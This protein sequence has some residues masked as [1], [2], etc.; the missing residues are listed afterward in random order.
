MIRGL[1]PSDI[2]YTLTEKLT[3][4]VDPESRVRGLPSFQAYHKRQGFL[5]DEK[6]YF[7][8]DRCHRDIPIAILLE[9]FTMDELLRL[10]ADDFIQ[11]TISE[12]IQKEHFLLWKIEN[13]LWQFEGGKR[14]PRPVAWGVN[15]LKR[16]SVDLPDFEIAVT[17]T[18]FYH[19]W[20]LTEHIEDLW[21]DAPMAALIYYRGEH[22]LTCSFAIRKRSIFVSQV[23]LRKKTGNRF[24]FK[25]KQH[26]LDFALD[27]LARAFGPN[28]WLTGGASA[29][30]AIRRAYGKAPCKMTTEDELRIAALYNRP[31]ERF[32]REGEPLVVQDREFIRLVPKAEAHPLQ[33]PKGRRPKRGRA[34]SAHPDHAQ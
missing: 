28:I 14:D 4:V 31:L 13:C 27:I 18:M 34:D 3:K 11:S 5:M 32:D 20:G 25:L 2:P 6:D 30:L 19:R 12:W 1:L 33:A 16:L 9:A 23:Q 10:H 21:I 17:H 22:V 7:T 24:L 29:V 8:W 26:V 15:G